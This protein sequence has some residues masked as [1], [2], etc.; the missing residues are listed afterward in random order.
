M[1]YL[2]TRVREGTVVILRK[3]QVACR[4]A[5]SGTVGPKQNTN[6]H[7]CHQE[8]VPLGPVVEIKYLEK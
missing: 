4:F 5:H 8:C 3:H 2:K 1:F 6:S 7:F